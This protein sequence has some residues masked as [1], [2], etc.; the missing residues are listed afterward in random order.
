MHRHI[1]IIELF[2]KRFS[3]VLMQ[4]G[5]I[6]LI[7]KKISFRFCNNFANIFLMFLFEI[8]LTQMKKIDNIKEYTFV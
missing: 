5:F 1:P 4:T 7:V 2:D 6:E 3:F 8:I